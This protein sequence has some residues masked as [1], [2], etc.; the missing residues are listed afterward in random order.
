MEHRGIAAGA[1]ETLMRK[2]ETSVHERHEKH[3]QGK[4]SFYF[5]IFVL[6]VDK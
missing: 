4:S 3:E 1:G 6:F 5:V 2:P